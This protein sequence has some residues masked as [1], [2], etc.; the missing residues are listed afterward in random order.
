MELL[1]LTDKHS[2]RYYLPDEDG[3]FTPIFVNIIYERVR[4]GY[5]YLDDDALTAQGL[6]DDFWAGEDVKEDVLAFMK[7]RRLHEYEDWDICDT[8]N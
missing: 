7:R 6:V 3:D 4:E 5:W 8:E 1:V 2:T